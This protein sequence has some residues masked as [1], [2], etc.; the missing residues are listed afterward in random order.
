MIKKIFLLLVFVCVLLV[1]VF[2]LPKAKVPEP[3]PEPSLATSSVHDLS[4][5]AG[6]LG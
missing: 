3:V 5:A 4:D 2:L 1:S 6:G